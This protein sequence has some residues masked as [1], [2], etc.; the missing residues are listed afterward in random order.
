MGCSWGVLIRTD[1]GRAGS[2]GG[3]VRGGRM[4][5]RRTGEQM[6]SE[7]LDVRPLVWR[8]QEDFP[9][10]LARMRNAIVRMALRRCCGFLCCRTASVRGQCPHEAVM[11]GITWNLHS[12]RLAVPRGW[13]KECGRIRSATPFERPSLNPF[14]KG[15]AQGRN[16]D[17]AIEWR[18]RTAPRV[19]GVRSGIWHA[20]PGADGRKWHGG[21]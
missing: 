19:R 8:P 12:S 11:H 17:G 20:S 6:D 5:F 4:V 3:V 14:R 1:C 2:D 16:D 18:R 13:A 15:F 10:A 7:S 21:R 9:S